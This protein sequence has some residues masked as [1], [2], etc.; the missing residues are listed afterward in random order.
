MLISALDWGAEFASCS[1]CFTFWERTL[2]PSRQEG[3]GPKDSMDV[4]DKKKSLVPAK[5]TT[6]DS[7]LH[8]LD[9]ILTV[10]SWHFTHIRKFWAKTEN[11]L[12]YTLQT[13]ANMEVHDLR[14]DT[15]INCATWLNN[16]EFILVTPLGAGTNKIPWKVW[17]ESLSCN[18]YWAC[19][20]G[21]WLKYRTK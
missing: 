18:S 10:L 6:M 19:E 17:T 14:C 8:S 16:F 4:L 5:I 9:T 20:A 21:L 12:N 15:C 1:S 13:P 2:V 7:S 3:G 11:K